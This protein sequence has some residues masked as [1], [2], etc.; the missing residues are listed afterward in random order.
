[1]EPAIVAGLH[2]APEICRREAV[3]VVACGSTLGNLL[4]FVRGEDKAFRILVEAVGGG[5]GGSG[6]GGA[7]TVFLIRR[8]NSPTELIPEVRGYG[9]TFPEH[10][11]TWGPDARGST[12][13]ERLLRYRFGGLRFLVRFSAD[14]YIEEEPGR[15]AATG[16]RS[17]PAASRT[18]AASVSELVSSLGDARISPEVVASVASSSGRSRL[19]IRAGGGLVDQGGIFD[20]KTRSSRRRSDDTLGGELP[21]MWVAQIPRFILAYHDWGVFRDIQIHDIRE[22]VR[23]WEK[24]HNDDLSRLAA[25]V[26]RIIALLRTE[27][28]GRVRKLELCHDGAGVLEVRQ[29]LPDTADAL[30]PTVKAIWIAGRQGVTNKEKETTEPVGDGIL[31]WKDDSEG[32]FTACSATCGYCGQC[33]S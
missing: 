15:S 14:G 21:R 31:E 33:G 13:H 16:K 19:T 30:S 23:A 25:L 27:S 24:A 3:D 29:A 26:H 8:E 32:D 20:L 7:G 17:S 6:G 22:K 28:P 9:H 2:A 4:R 11:T 18:S 10:Y 1:M 5:S 12:S